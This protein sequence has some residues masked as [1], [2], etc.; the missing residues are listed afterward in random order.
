MSNESEERKSKSIEQAEIL[1]RG[2]RSGQIHSFIAVAVGETVDEVYNSGDLTGK[3][4][5]T[6][7]LGLM[8]IVQVGM[9]GRFSAT[10]WVRGPKG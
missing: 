7:L 8:T 6:R 4:I 5:G 10:D 3:H 9:A 1:L 2:L